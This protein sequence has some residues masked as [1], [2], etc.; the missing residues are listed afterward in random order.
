MVVK[1]QKLQTKI[2]MINSN[3]DLLKFLL[4]NEKP[5]KTIKRKLV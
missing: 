3:V 1:R 2:E 5:K 4:K